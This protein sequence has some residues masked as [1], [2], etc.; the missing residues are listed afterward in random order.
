M[1]RKLKK[2][3]EIFGLLLI[4]SIVVFSLYMKS[5]YSNVPF[6]ELYFYIFNGVTNSDSGVFTSAII[7]SLPYIIVLFALLF[8]IF[9]DVTRGKNKFKFYPINFINKHRGLII[10][11]TLVLSK[12]I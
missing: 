6:E 11:I 10:I 3:M 7:Q 12:F 9:F 8:V 5:T 4:A 2:V 1:K